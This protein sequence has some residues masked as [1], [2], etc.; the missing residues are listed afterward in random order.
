MGKNILF[1]PTDDCP[2]KDLIALNTALWMASR[3]QGRVVYVD[4]SSRSQASIETLLSTGRPR[5]FSDLSR[6]VDT[7]GAA[8]MRGYLTSASGLDLV[9]GSDAPTVSHSERIFH[10]LENSYECVIVNS[11]R[12][13]AHHACQTAA[14]R[15]GVTIL[16]FN[17]DLLSMRQAQEL[18]DITA[19]WHLPRS[20]VQLLAG[21]NGS[22]HMIPENQIIDFFHTRLI[23]RIA[24]DENTI[25]AALN[26]GIQ[27]V[28]AQPANAFSRS[29]ASTVARLSEP[30]LY[31]SKT[32]DTSPER[33]GDVNLKALKETIHHE[34]ISE[35]ERS[36]IDAGHTGAP[37]TPELRTAILK[38][39]QAIIA[40]HD[41]VQTP[42]TAELEQDLMD[43]I[44]GLGSIEK[45]L[46]D[47]SVTEIMI[48]GPERIYCERK[49]KIIATESTFS[50]PQKLMT[51]I[52]RIVSPIGRRIDE[53]SPLVDA[54][55][56]DGSRV[57]IVIPPLALKGATVTIRKFSEK[58]L[59]VDDL[60]GFGALTRPMADF[61]AVCVQLRMNIIVSGGTGSGKTTLLNVISSFIPSDERIVTIEDS[62]ELRLPQDH[63][64]SLESR[65]PS[66][67]GTGEISIRRLVINA[68]RMRPDRIV[69]GECRGGETLDMLQAMNTGHDGSLTTIHANTPKDGIARIA[70][71]VIMAGTELPDKAI[72][73]QIASA[74]QVI[75]Q[76]SRMADG[77]RKVVE[78]AEVTGI[79]NDTVR[80]S[81]LFTFKQTGFNEGTVQGNFRATGTLPTFMDDITIHGLNLD[82]SIFTQGV[83]E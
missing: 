61:L 63:V 12:L 14:Q 44:L 23:G 7:P 29:V 69:V 62:A 77:T 33:P 41:E 66:L 25:M 28:L 45:L 35:L 16:A 39:V 1:M 71:M 31:R 15:A 11:S 58:K 57:N 5:S 49:G 53:S 2:F 46:K 38:T 26:S 20:S 32:S 74:V 36:K 64:V 67:E 73:E 19:S 48:N 17:P 56:L 47:P 10:M 42:D 9:S 13:A 27:P 76:L 60:I 34:V 81:T 37:C 40:Q 50:T 52:D 30:A 8:L 3:K 54:R 21:D 80:L 68:L 59:T 4:L 72:R 83:N 24:Y 43:D 79:E 6:L 65:P 18:L 75:V 70:T 55:L 51:V 78:I 22:A 82:R